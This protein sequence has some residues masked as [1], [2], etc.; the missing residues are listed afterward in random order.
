MT[1]LYAPNALPLAR[2]W[3]RCALSFKPT[4]KGLFL[5]LQSD[6]RA[7]GPQRPQSGRG[8]QVECREGLTHHLLNM[9]K[10]GD[11]TSSET[12]EYLLAQVEAKL[13]ALPM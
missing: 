6:A 3:A 4:V 1:C 9:N 5:F 7:V 12:I 8:V 10:D 11:P 13:N 2:R